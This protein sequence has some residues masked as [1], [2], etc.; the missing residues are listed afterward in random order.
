MQIPR[1]R[2]NPRTAQHAHTLP[3]TQTRAG[4][5]C[6][7][8]I[9]MGAAQCSACGQLNF[10]FLKLSG[11]FHPEYLPRAGGRVHRHRGRGGLVTLLQSVTG[12]SRRDSRSLPLAWPHSVQ[13]FIGTVF[14]TLLTTPVPDGCCYCPLSCADVPTSLMERLSGRGKRRAQ[15]SEGEDGPGLDSFES[16]GPSRL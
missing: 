7:S 10:C 4:H 12:S 3:R 9:C 14:V 2:R 11:I 6:A 13:S 8:R 16:P 5:A 15:H 1:G